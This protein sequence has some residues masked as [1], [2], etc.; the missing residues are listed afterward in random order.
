MKDFNAVGSNLK[1]NEIESIQIPSVIISMA[2]KHLKPKN[3]SMLAERSYK[4]FWI[5]SIQY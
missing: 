3:N 5:V 4:M 1:L 2:F